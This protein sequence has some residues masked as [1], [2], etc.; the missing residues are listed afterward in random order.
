MSKDRNLYG[1]LCHLIGSHL[2]PST[3]RRLDVF[4]RTVVEYSSTLGPLGYPGRTFPCVLVHV[5]VHTTILTGVRERR[6]AEVDLGVVRR[7]R[8][9]FADD[10]LAS[11]VLSYTWQASVR[12][13]D[14]GEFDSENDR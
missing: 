7:N 8:G 12:T 9:S 5:L 3:L 2:Q 14:G 11:R 13:S 1:C 6:N 4:G 10:L